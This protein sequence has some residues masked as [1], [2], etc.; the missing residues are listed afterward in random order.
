MSG[1]IRS[2]TISEGDA[3]AVL[4]SASRPFGATCTSYPAFRRYMA[5]KDAIDCSS[6]TTKTVCASAPAI[7][8]LRMP[9]R[10][11]ANGCGELEPHP[12]I[13]ERGIIHVVQRV[14]AVE[15]NTVARVAPAVHPP[16]PASDGGEVHA[17]A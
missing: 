2:R 4:A 7:A 11:R 17:L 13:G 5:T 16:I 10:L 1:S 12:F 3:A 14:R 8:P 9:D 6:S 15:E